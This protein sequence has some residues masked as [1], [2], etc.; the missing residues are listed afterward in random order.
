VYLA[1]VLTLTAG[2]GLVIRPGGSQ[3]AEEPRE[4]VPPPAPLELEAEPAPQL[5]LAWNLAADDLAGWVLE[6]AE[7]SPA[8]EHL[9]FSAEEGLRGV[10]LAPDAD[11]DGYSLVL[12]GFD[13]PA[14]QLD[15]FTLVASFPRA[16]EAQLAFR[17]ADD[18][19]GEFPEGQLLRVPTTSGETSSDW[20]F[21]V[22]THPAWSGRIVALRLVPC[23]LG[24]GCLVEGLRSG[25]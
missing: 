5:E 19:P 15:A 18:E 22:S 8:R 6:G 21:E 10:F 20:T 13:L 2:L 9:P 14:E 12:E 23:A 24:G 16:G 17:T 1:A 7:A 11:A 25:R 3:E 4:L